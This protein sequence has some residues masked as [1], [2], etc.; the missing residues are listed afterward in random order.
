MTKQSCCETS[1][2]KIYMAG[3]Y[4]VAK[5]HIREF[6]IFNNVCIN[7]YKTDY[8]YRGG[9]ESGFCVEI[10]NYP[11]YPEKEQTLQTL[12]II[13][14]EELLIKCCQKSYTVAS[15]NETC[16]YSREDELGR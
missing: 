4:F 15:A 14:A 11:K 12:A 10:I 1:W 2:F 9:E 5:Q 6:C 8:I 13:L 7:I 16:Y 3:D